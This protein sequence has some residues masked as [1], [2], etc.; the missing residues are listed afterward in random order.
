MSLKKNKKLNSDFNSFTISLASPESILEGSYGEV[1]QPETINYR[2]YKPEMGG[3]FCER[4]FGPVKDWECHCG[5]Y[6]RIRYKGIICDRCGV[7]VTEKKVRR[8]RMGHIELVVPVAHIWYFKSLP[9]KIG[10]LLGLSSKKLDQVIYYER[11]VVIQP[12]IKEE[13]GLSQMDFL[14]EEEYLDVLD[15]LPRENQM[16]PDEDPQKFIA[17]MGAEALYM[18]LSRLKLDELSYELRHQAATDNSQQRKAEALKRLKVVESFR[19]AQTRIENKPEWM[20]IRMV[21]VIPPELRPLVPLDGGRFATSDLNDLY[22]RVIIR[23]NRLKRLLEI[24]A[25]EVILRNEKRMLQEAVDSLF[26]N[27]RKVN[28][29]RSDGNRALKSLSDMLKG[30][31]GRFRQNLLGKRVDYSGRSVIVV[32]PEL[33]LHECGLPKDMAAELFKPFIIRKLIER[34]IVKTVKSA[35]KIVDRKDA[36]IWDILENVL[37]GH[38]VLLNRAPTLHRLGIQAFQPKLVEGKAIQLHPLVCTAFNADFDGDQMAVHVPLSQE[39][40]MEASILMLSSHN[41]LNPAN[42]A[43]ITVPSQDMVLGLYYVTKGKRSTPEE[44]ILGEDKIFYSAEEVIIALNEGRL[45]KHAFIKVKAKV[46]DENG[47]LVEKMIDTVAGRVLFNQFVP[48]KVGYINE[49]L[50]KK[51]LQGIIGKVFKEVSFARTA[52]FLDDIKE[53]GFQSAFRGGLSIGLGDIMIPEEK[54]GLIDNAREEVEE[55]QNNYMFGIITERERYNQ[56]IDIWTR[57]NTRL[58]ET[59]LRQLENDR[60]GFN[61]VYMMMHSGARGSQ[62]QIRQLGG[63][64]GL[65]AKPQKNIAGSVGEIIENP[66]LSNF[67]EGLDVL[68]Y[69]ISTHGAR[70]GLADTALKTADAGY[71]TRRLHDVAQDVVVNEEDC[72]TL[73]GI[74]VSALKENDDVIEPLSE[75]ILGR[76]SVHDIIDPITKELIL[77]AGEEITEEIAERVDET[78][79]ET[80]EIRSPL[81]CETKVGVCAKCYGRNLASGRMVDVGE[82]V[83]VIASQS[84]GEPG[85]QLTLRTFHTGGTAMNV[86]VEANLKAKFPGKISFEDVRTVEY[87]NKEGEVNTIVIGRRGEIRIIDPAT[88][89]LLIS[90]NIPYGSTLLVKDGETVEKGA[91]LCNWDQFNAVIMTEFDGVVEYESIEEGVTYREEADEQTGFRDKVITDSKDRAKNP[92]II[93]K[94]ASG[95]TK[96]YN[97]PV[98]ARLMVENGQE[99]KA[100]Q[101][102]AKIPRAINMNR[103]ITGGLPRVTELFEA[104]NPSN[105]AVVSEIDG[106]VSYGSIK[107][108][109]REI[110][111]EAK[112]GTKM[113]YMVS[114]SKLILVQEGDFI[115]AGEPLS[116]GAITP[117][118]ILRIKGPTAVQEYLV[119]ETQAVYRQQGVKISDKHIEVIVRQMMQKVDV[120]DA[121]D[122]MFL[123]MQ[124]VDKWLFREENDKIFDKKVV[125]DAGASENYKP[126]QII[127]TREFK[128]ENSRLKREDKKQMTVRDAQPAVSQVILQGITTAS[129][130]TESFVSAASFQETTKVL[131][132]AAV[133]G[134]RDDLAGLKENV[135]VG[136]LIPAGT[137]RRKY[138]NIQVNS[139]EEIQAANA[140]RAAEPRKREYVD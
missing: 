29:V 140:A 107:R 63:M 27:S 139:L 11:Y 94:S 66:I 132:E 42:G 41:I 97:L 138:Q 7:E 80:I 129:L 81:T 61:P 103:D 51:K 98:S 111:V 130:G 95:E 38:P 64:R 120:L 46:K 1:T 71:L 3:L 8:E 102:L 40:I 70:K 72:G 16:L 116:D 92:A 25:P 105:P 68:E 26:D 10:Y 125:V 89:Q 33:K 18:L 31:Q 106:V 124:A 104:R 121:G 75:R 28:A 48:E 44:P 96:D 50:T 93:I 34:G 52:Q 65:M 9:N 76:T 108:G 115:R 123:E 24:K 60:Q 39:A 53:L 113:K 35:K 15:K 119:N 109:N 136:H 14:T 118:D 117:A 127:S 30:K 86:S 135:I 100:G 87:T 23:N 69:F 77:A 43:P 91:P 122:T 128:D 62:E 110:F 58:R 73:R 54:Q 90:N 78:S 84:I 137:G 88:N 47:E 49:L 37:K 79:I 19:D 126:G 131:S 112:D 36:V 134:K 32:G 57:V 82:A 22:R 83:G 56:I 4:I 99:V 20:I 45:S 13:D 85:T 133:K 67:K 12:G 21:P 59:L 6:K 55:V 74:N 101:I 114:L 5:K 17:K 2:T